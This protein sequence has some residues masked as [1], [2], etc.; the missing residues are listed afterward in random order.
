RRSRESGTGTT[1]SSGPAAASLGE[2][3]PARSGARASSPRNLSA[4]MSAS[5]G[6]SYASALTVASY[7]GG[8]A[9]QGP[10]S[11]P[12]G[13]ASAQRGQA[14]SG[15]LGSSASHASQRSPAAAP[16][17][18]KQAPPNTRAERFFSMLSSERCGL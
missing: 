14:G 13:E 6:N 4:W 5:A 11:A 10:Q 3:R 7:A 17:Q 8:R 2:S 16:R 18:R 15:A 9:R 12:P 1:R